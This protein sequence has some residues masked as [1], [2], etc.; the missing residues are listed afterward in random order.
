[1]RAHFLLAAAA[2]A[3]LLSPAFSFSPSPTLP[4]LRRT[5]GAL[6]VRHAPCGMATGL[7]MQQD[8]STPPKPTTGFKKLFGNMKKQFDEKPLQST[9]TLLFLGLTQPFI[10]I[11]G[12]NLFLGLQEAT[13]GARPEAVL[14]P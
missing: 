5:V 11:F 3:S 4:S 2:V 1:M 10:L 8:P 12:F 6:G 13:L 7:R 9:F 14:P